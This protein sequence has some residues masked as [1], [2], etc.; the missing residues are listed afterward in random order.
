MLPGALEDSKRVVR[1]IWERFGND[2]LLS[3]MNQY[4]PV[5]ADAAQAGDAWAQRQLQRCP[6]LGGRVS[7]GEY[8]E[9]LDYADSLGIED[10]FWQQGG[11]AKDSF[12]PAFDLTGVPR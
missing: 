12:I 3:L 11:A 5:L 6:E 4:T 9:L 1:T 10:Y 8:E 2:V 7:D